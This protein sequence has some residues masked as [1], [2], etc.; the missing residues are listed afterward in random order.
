MQLRARGLADGD[1][2]SCATHGIS[3]E[4]TIRK[5]L[6]R[7]RPVR[8]AV[9]NQI[10]HR[11]DER[12]GKPERHVEVRGEEEFRV[13][14][15]QQ[16]GKGDM[17]PPRVVSNRKRDCLRAFW[18]PA[19]GCLVHEKR[20]LPRLPT[21]EESGGKFTYETSDP[22]MGCG[23]AAVEDDTRHGCSIAHMTIA[24]A[25]S[26]SDL[27]GAHEKEILLS[28]AL[29]KNT[30]WLM[31][32]GEEQVTA[33]QEERY[34]LALARRKSGEPIAYITGEKEFYGR[35]FFVDRS[36]LIPRPSTE[37]LVELTLETLATGR[38][39]ERDAD[40]GI[41]VSSHVLRRWGKDGGPSIL[42]DVGTGSGCIAVTLALALPHATVIA[43]DVSPHAIERARRNV[44]AY[45]LEQRIRLVRG[46]LLAGNENVREPF[47]VVSNPPYIPDDQELPESTQRFEPH[48]ALRGGPDGTK[49]IEKLLKACRS[50]PLCRGVALEYRAD[51]REKILSML[52]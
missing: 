36:V 11:A 19:F 15:L 48:L 38:G 14:P 34:R 46:S 2:G 44:T 7:R 10:V 39:G 47:F 32:H 3:Q 35:T 8:K 45:G 33:E 28:H 50:H 25:L 26:L 43:T 24:S 16:R 31:A 12:N 9:Q 29:G 6:P 37:T 1:D 4:Q 23:E 17:F 30:A 41:I 52:G 13:R 5:A 22:R 18:N 21:L 42:M 40:S 49:V 27:D 51:Q 20:V